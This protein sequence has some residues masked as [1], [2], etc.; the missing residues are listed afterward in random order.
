M[1]KKR[2]VVGI[3]LIACVAA[4]AIL[5]IG[6]PFSEEPKAEATA[7]KTVPVQLYPELGE[8]AAVK[9]EDGQAACG[10]YDGLSTKAIMLPDSGGTLSYNGTMLSADYTKK[11]VLVTIDGPSVFVSGWVTGANDAFVPFNVPVE[12]TGDTSPGLRLES[13]DFQALTDGIKDVTLCS[14]E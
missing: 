8:V 5:V 2:I 14:M 10:N 12:A 7:E 11:A 13:V 4:I 6:N 1:V 9:I 3:I